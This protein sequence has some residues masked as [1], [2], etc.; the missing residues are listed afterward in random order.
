MPA[1]A[2]TLL[3]EGSFAEL[4]EELSQYIDNIG[5]SQTE[6]GS[7]LQA[8]LAPA[9]AELR[10]QEQAEEEP[11]QAQI[12]QIYKERQEV[13]K[14]L[15]AASTVLNSAPEKGLSTTPYPTSAYPFL[16]VHTDGAQSSRQ[17]TTSLS[18]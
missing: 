4:A 3:I 10:K 8:E 17:P 13:L 1:P 15:V 6:D 2:N 16:C 18:T 9:L 5:K 14:K 11:N 7:G 12:E